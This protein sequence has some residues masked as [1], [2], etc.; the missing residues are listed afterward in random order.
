[1]TNIYYVVLFGKYRGK[2]YIKFQKYDLKISQYKIKGTG[3]FYSD[4]QD[5]KVDELLHDENIWLTQ[6]QMA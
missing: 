5:V 3:T 2:S 6:E 4:K 1:L